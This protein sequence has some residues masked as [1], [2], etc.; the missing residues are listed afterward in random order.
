MKNTDFSKNQKSEIKEFLKT[1]KKIIKSSKVSP[2]FL[3]YIISSLPSK[4][5]ENVF[6]KSNK[7]F[8]KNFLPVKKR[9]FIEFMIKEIEK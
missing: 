2:S 4:N 6:T 9:L 7:M 5:N 1:S 8:L 3:L